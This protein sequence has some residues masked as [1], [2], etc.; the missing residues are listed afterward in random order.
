MGYP[1]DALFD[2]PCV[3]IS[4][5]DAAVIEGCKAVLLCGEERMSFDMGSFT[6]SFYGEKMLIEELSR[7]GL[8]LAGRIRSITLDVKGV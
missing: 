4:G 7:A 5:R 3:H 1:E 8:K 2:D 6:V